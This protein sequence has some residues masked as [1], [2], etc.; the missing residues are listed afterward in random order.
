[1]TLTHIDPLF[2]KVNTIGGIIVALFSF[3]FGEHWV[4]FVG[5]LLLNVCDYFTGCLKSRLNSKINS[6]KG[7]HGILKKLGY[8]IMIMVAFG[9]SVMFIEIGMVVGI[10]LHITTLIGWFVL[11]ALIVNEFRSIIENLVECG[12]NVP[13]ILVKGLEIADKAIEAVEDELDDD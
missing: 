9:M 10:D 13:N 7:L 3:V 6:G 4:L 5:F 8:W 12:Y 11:A 1:M 2:D